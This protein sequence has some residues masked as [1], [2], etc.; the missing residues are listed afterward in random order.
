MPLTRLIN[1][2]YP[3]ER[4][5][6][7]YDL[8]P[9]DYAWTLHVVTLHDG[10]LR[11]QMRPGAETFLTADKGPRRV[12]G[13]F[14]KAAGKLVEALEV[15]GF[16]TGSGAAID[17]GASPGGWTVQLAQRFELAIAVDPADMHPS[18]LLPNV[19]HVRRMSQDATEEIEAA[20]A[21]RAVDLVCCDA[22]T[23]PFAVVELLRPVLGMLRPGGLLVL[24]LKYRGKG[25]DKEDHFQRVEEIVGEGFTDFTHL[26]LCANTRTE[27]TLVARR[28]G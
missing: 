19:V 11:F 26:W 28:R 4:V 25:K 22:N 18:A 13:Q 5:F 8:H 23:H 15:S 24:T 1:P 27:R 20:L 3:Q 17:V 12:P 21:G 2:F 10:T 16:Q 7:L 14:C 6:D 9:V